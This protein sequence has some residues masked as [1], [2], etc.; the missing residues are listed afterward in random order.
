[1]SDLRLEALRLCRLLDASSRGAR[2]CAEHE[3]GLWLGD[4]SDPEGVLGRRSEVR[5]TGKWMV[6]EVGELSRWERQSYLQEWEK[7]GIVILFPHVRGV[8]ACGC[9]GGWGSGMRVAV[10]GSWEEV[11]RRLGDVLDSL[12]V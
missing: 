6:K 9:V 10:A 2:L 5:Y 4:P 3:G 11:V 8:A 1:M 7:G 12:L